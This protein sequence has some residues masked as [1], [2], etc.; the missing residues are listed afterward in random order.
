MKA[1][2]D[3]L[4]MRVIKQWQAGKRQAELAALFE[5]SAGS[6]KRWVKQYKRPLSSVQ[7]MS[8]LSSSDIQPLQALSE[9]FCA[10]SINLSP[11]AAN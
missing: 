11:Y 5:V 3:D 2:S 6:V 7:V 4:R 10:Q 9:E 8:N 1:Y